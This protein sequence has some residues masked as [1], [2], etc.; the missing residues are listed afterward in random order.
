MVHMLHPFRTAETGHKCARLSARTEGNFSLS[1]S[2]GRVSRWH[3]H[4]I[5]RWHIAYPARHI[6]S[7]ASLYFFRHLEEP[8]PQFFIP[9]PKCRLLCWF[10]EGLCMQKESH[11]R[12]FCVWK[13]LQWYVRASSQDQGSNP[14][15]HSFCPIT[16]LRLSI[17]FSCTGGKKHSS[18]GWECALSIQHFKPCNICCFF[19]YQHIR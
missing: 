16:V 8:S 5:T 12:H 15:S 14:N 13:Q 2:Y 3:R 6:H 11:R 10:D 18:L 19:T 1:H 7:G 4:K 17:R 9:A